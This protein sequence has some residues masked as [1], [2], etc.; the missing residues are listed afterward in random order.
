VVL[1]GNRQKCRE[2]DEHV[3]RVPVDAERI[4]AAIR[5]QLARGAYPPSTLY[6][7]GHVAERIAEQLER[8]SP[9]IQ[10]QLAF[11]Q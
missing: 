2:C 7:D 3:T 1:V 4:A 6:G 5:A 10:K 8:L 9:Y 11:A